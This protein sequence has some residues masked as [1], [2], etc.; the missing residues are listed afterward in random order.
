MVDRKKA[1]AFL[2]EQIRAAILDGLYKPGERRMEADVAAQ[3]HVSR[4]PVRETLQTLES[5]GT[6]VATPYLGAMVRPL[7]GAEARE[8]AEIRL[9]LISL[10]LKPAHPH[11]APTHFYLA[12]DLAKRITRT[13][14]AGEAFERASIFAPANPR[15][16]SNKPVFDGS[17]PPPKENTCF[18]ARPDARSGSL[19]FFS[20]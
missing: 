17:R 16:P 9:G 6:L 15:R 8:I 18:S 10:A 2:I 19:H 4:S 5:E 20:C 1:P 12:Y 11:L 3:F 7:S 13:K 14:S